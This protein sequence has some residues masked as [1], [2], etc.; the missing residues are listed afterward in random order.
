V[1]ASA[2]DADAEL[3]GATEHA[4]EG[5]EGRTPLLALDGFNG[6]LERLLTLARA[7]QVDLARVPLADLVDQLTA[8][9]RGAPPAMPLSQKGDWV[10]MA[11]WL[12]QLR[13][14][15]LL[16]AGH[17]QLGCRSACELRLGR[18]GGRDDDSCLPELR[19]LPLPG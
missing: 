6:P 15:L 7:R 9:W 18:V 12:L 2:A 13:S 16:P 8:A 4:T 14:L 17:R 1:D 10:V 11:A 5:G 3:D 19:R